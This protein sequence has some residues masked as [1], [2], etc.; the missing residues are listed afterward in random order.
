[1]KI[2]KVSVLLPFVFAMGFSLFSVPAHAQATRTWVSGVGS[3]ANPCSR[4]APCK[5]FAG[6]I[7]KTAPGGEIDALDPGGFGAVTITKAITLDGGGG[8]I[9]SILV[10][11]TNAINVNAGASDVVILR[12][13]RFDGLNQ[14]VNPGL[15]AIQFNSGGTLIVEK[16]D[17]FGFNND[18]IGIVP[19]NN[20]K[21]SISETHIQNTAVTA[22]T[23]GVRIAPTANVTVMVS[24]SWVELSGQN[25]I[26][27]NGGGAGV[28]RLNVKESVVT[29][30]GGNGVQITSGGTVVTGEVTGTQI[31]YAGGV[32]AS[33]AGGSASLTLGENTITNNVTGVSA[34]SG[35]LLS[36]KNNM[37]ADNAS[38]GTPITAV[39]GY[40]NGGQ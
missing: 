36:Y 7:S 9:A 31:S 38:N 14:S 35:I 27:A 39:A 16:C 1:M 2:S 13:L 23:A 40:T 28:I 5:T 19:T 21:V 33:V 32:G 22:N 26:F 8:Q 11:G 15:T 10:A 29:H 25:G 30:S 12:N 4:T 3:D 17:I 37:I 18:G 34:P 6:A 24:K 20:S